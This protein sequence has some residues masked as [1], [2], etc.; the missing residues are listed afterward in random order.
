LLAERVAD[1]VSDCA[2][3]AAWPIPPVA[4]TGSAEA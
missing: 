3:C 1:A 4:P 2:C